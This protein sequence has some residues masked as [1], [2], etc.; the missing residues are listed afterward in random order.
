MKKERW[1][2]KHT[3]WIRFL[4][5]PVPQDV[6][7]WHACINASRYVTLPRPKMSRPKTLLSTVLTN[8]HAGKRK[9]FQI[10]TSYFRGSRMLT[11]TCPLSISFW[12]LL[13][14]QTHCFHRRPPRVTSLFSLVFSL[15]SMLVQ[16]VAGAPG[17]PGVPGIPG[18]PG[19]PGI[20]G[21]PGVPGVPGCPGFPWREQSYR[22]D[23]ERILKLL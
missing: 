10:S 7:L 2:L 3:A 20:P 11:W 14:D 4:G 8:L 21:D 13:D 19:V 17:A 22:T 9:S 15:L 6:E 18:V 5:D 12:A 16:V 23:N 1:I